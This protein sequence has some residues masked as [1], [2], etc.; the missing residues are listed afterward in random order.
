MDPQPAFGPKNPLEGR[1]SH[2][3]LDRRV[4]R[5]GSSSLAATNAG[6]GF[7]LFPRLKSRV[8]MVV[9]FEE[10]FFLGK[11]RGVLFEVEL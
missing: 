5:H 2:Q 6:G 9:S 7:P 1:G 11:T 8:G 3:E 10:S 4:W